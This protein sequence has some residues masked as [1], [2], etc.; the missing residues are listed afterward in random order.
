MRI[1]GIDPGSVVTGFGLLESREKKFRLLESGAIRPDPKLPFE[2]RL[3]RIYDELL[4][5]ISE[6]TPDEVALESIYHGENVK[7]TMKLCHARGVIILA[8]VNSNLPL[9]EY[10][11]TEVKRAVVGRGSASKSQVRFMVE[12]I[13]GHLEI[14]KGHDT[15]DA[16]ALAICH[17]HRDRNNDRSPDRKDSL[18]E[19]LRKMGA[20]DGKRRG[21]TN[22]SPKPKRQK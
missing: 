18:Q 9:F 11:P 14:G 20:F 3:L 10:T 6:R 13:L 2:K 22:P 19:K 17:S 5:L 15:S 12:Q 4:K 1:L 7:T 16:I 8:V 21:S